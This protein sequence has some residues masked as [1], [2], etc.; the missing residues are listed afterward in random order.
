MRRIFGDEKDPWSSLSKVI[1]FLFATIGI[2]AVGGN[3]LFPNSNKVEAQTPDSSWWLKHVAYNDKQNID[4][5]CNLLT[6]E[7][8]Y[9]LR[10]D[11]HGEPAISVTKNVDCRE[12]LKSLSR[13]EKP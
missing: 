4:F 5:S 8:I 2:I 3:Y 7:S 1:I 13:Y 10:G 12:V 6:G 9:T 11:Y